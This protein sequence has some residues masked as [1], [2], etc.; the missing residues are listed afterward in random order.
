MKIWVDQT[1]L[2]VPLVLS[3]KFRNAKR[4]SREEQ[5]IEIK[6]FEL[7]RVAIFP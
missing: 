7:N 1:T 6:I 3:K 2:I 5:K 4:F